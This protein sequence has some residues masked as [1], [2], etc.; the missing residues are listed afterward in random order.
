[1]VWNPGALVRRWFGRA[2]V[3][4]P[5]DLKRIGADDLAVDTLGQL[6]GKP[7][8]SRRRR[9]ANYDDFGKLCLVHRLSKRFSIASHDIRKY[10]GRP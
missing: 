10:T 2:D 5:V 6:Q 7:R 1:M 8:L 9:A 3:E 4:P